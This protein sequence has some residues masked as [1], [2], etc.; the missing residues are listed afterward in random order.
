MKTIKLSLST[1]KRNQFIDITAEIETR[2][3][4]ETGYP[5]KKIDGLCVIYSPHTTAGIMIN[6]NAD[7]DVCIDIDRRL[8]SLIPEK[9][10]YRHFEGNSD[11]HIKSA[12]ISVSQSVI[13]E[14]SSLLLGR[15]QSIFFCEFDGPRKRTVYIK[16]INSL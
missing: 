14:E 1:E 15:W 13:I 6:E 4:A 9:S 3:R 10:G 2:V 7:P 12:L 16:I 11:S 5:D 8:S